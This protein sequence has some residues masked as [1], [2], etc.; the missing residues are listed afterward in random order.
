MIMIFADLST[1][2]TLMTYDLTMI[3]TRLIRIV[4][5]TCGQPIKYLVRWLFLT[6][7]IND[8]ID[9]Q[10]TLHEFSKYWSGGFL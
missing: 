3:M 8:T 6:Q 4:Q 1:K 7:V 2:R 5:W 9:G 10:V